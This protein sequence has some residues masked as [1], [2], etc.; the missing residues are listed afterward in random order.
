MSIHASIMWA[1]MAGKIP[2]GTCG[3]ARIEHFTITKRESALSSFRATLNGLRSTI[4]D[5]GRYA[6]LLV[7]GG[8]M[9]TDTPMERIT[10]SLLIQM[11]RGHVLIAGLG[12][13]M[14]IW[15]LLA[16]VPALSSLVIVERNPDV[17]RLVEPHLPRD[18]RLVI[19]QADIFKWSPR[20]WQPCW[21]RFDT[22]YFDIWPDICK[23]NTAEAGK[24]RRRA[25][26]WVA[27][28]G[29]IGD[30]DTEVRLLD[31]RRA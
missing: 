4:V 18:S 9:M 16:K 1:E 13:G 29:W 19:V 10:N 26:G 25:K 17:I 28:G 27:P 12:L 20:R 8:I 15:P 23:S 30:W 31:G 3:S 7:D 6:R 14:M 22:V 24:L 11:A 21:S 2:E 5:P